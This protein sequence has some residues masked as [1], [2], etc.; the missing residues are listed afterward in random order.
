[1]GE[2]QSKRF[3]K[4]Y[5]DWYDKYCEQGKEK[6][7]FRILL[8]VIGVVSAGIIYYKGGWSFLYN[9]MCN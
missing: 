6:W 9:F 3:D 4:I 2:E 8:I 5:D 7:K 1:M